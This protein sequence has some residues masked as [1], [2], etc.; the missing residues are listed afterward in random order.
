M[1]ETPLDRDPLDR[2]PLI[3]K[4]LA[5]DPLT[6]T[7]LDRDP[8]VRQR[9]GSIHPTGMHSCLLLIF[10]TYCVDQSHQSCQFV[11]RFISCPNKKNAC[12]EQ[13]LLAVCVFSHIHFELFFVLS[14][15][16]H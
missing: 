7:P 4:T 2:D 3:E 9:A 6:E 8:C 15:E 10:S 11:L 12:F 1:T 13:M 14:F 16:D 5:R